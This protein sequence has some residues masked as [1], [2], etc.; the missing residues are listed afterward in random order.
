MPKTKGKRPPLIHVAQ[1]VFNT[2][3]M[4]YR[5]KLEAILTAVGGRLGLPIEVAYDDEDIV[6]RHDDGDKSS[7][8]VAIIPVQGTLVKR[9]DWMNS[10]SGLTSYESLR[11]CI[12]EAL[13]D[14]QVKTLLFDFDSPGGEAAGLF[15]FVNWMNSVKGQKPFVGVS[16]DMAYSAAYAIASAMDHLFVTEIGGIGSIGVYVLHV[17]TSKA[18]KKEGLKYT[19]IS[20]GEKK[21]DGNP[22]EPLS[23]SARNRM[24]ER[25]DAIRDMFV[26]LVAQNRGVDAKM[27]YDTEAELYMGE[28]GIPLLADAVG[29]YDEAAEYASNLAAGKKPAVARS[30]T[31][32]SPMVEQPSD[33]AAGLEWHVAYSKDDAL[34]IMRSGGMKEVNVRPL[35]AMATTGIATMRSFIEHGQLVL[36]TNGQYDTISGMLAP[37]GV[38][39]C[40]LG[41]FKEMY[42]PGCFAKS[43][44]IND[45]MILAYHDPSKPLGRKS[46]GTARF[47]EDTVGL[48]Y[49]VEL[50][51]TQDARDLKTSILR[52]DV[53]GASSA[54]FITRYT[55]KTVDGWRVRSVQEAELIEGSPHS[56]AAYKE[57]TAE[58]E[59]A[60]AAATVGEDTDMELM[61]VRLR[62]LETRR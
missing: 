61:G 25:V 62:L 35:G 41:G 6:E 17:D 52:G 7:G 21:V 13:E 32:R 29:S 43:L 19:Y 56:F 4:I 57:T 22:H 34:A 24:Q 12:T 1:R 37:Y 26:G 59:Q 55:W 50:P 45:P 54:F 51:D 23:D 5:P 46:T 30:H 8:P 36:T 42:E 31:P 58:V 3:L 18:D 9:G 14:P 2:P 49:E 15:D 20:S 28:K 53:R 11:S 10:M 39:S 48:R 44:E 16:N 40:D 33:V 60:P 47:W 38:L 27:I